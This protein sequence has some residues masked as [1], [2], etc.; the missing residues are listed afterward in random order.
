MQYNVGLK[1]NK[2]KV[3]TNIRF[4][5]MTDSKPLLLNTNGRRNKSQHCC[6][7]LANNVASVCMGLKV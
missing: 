7:I 6:V 5:P 4:G 2:L 3:L 1:C